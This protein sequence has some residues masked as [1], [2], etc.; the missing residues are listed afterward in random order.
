[1]HQNLAYGL[2]LSLRKGVKNI[3][4]GLV[5]CADGDL[6]T[7]DPNAAPSIIRRA[8]MAPCPAIT[9]ADHGHYSG[10]SPALALSRSKICA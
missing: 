2:V 7:L 1:M 5:E 8:V 9:C 10:R 4:P 6:E 3:R